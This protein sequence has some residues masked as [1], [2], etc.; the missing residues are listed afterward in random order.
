MAADTPRYAAES[1]Y[2]ATGIAGLDAVLGGGVARRRLY[3]IEGPPGAGKTT[4][5]LHFL[6]AGRD[7]HERCL[8]LTTAETPDEL[9]DAAQAHGWTLE[10]IEVFALPMVTRMAQPDQRQTLF[11]SSEVELD[12][13]MQEVMTILERV[14]PVRVVLDSLSILRDMADDLLA[15]RRQVLTLKQALNVGGC[16]ALVTDEGPMGSDMHVRTLAHGVVRLRQEVTLFG[17][18]QRQVEIVKMRGR[19]F[20]SGRHDLVITTGGIR[21]FPRLVLAAHDTDNTGELHSTGVVRLDALLGGGLNRGTATLLVGAAGTGKSSVTMQC[22]AAALQRGH[23]VAVYLFDERPATWFQRADALGFPLRQ[24]VTHGTL[25]VEQIDPAEM[26]PG[27]F[28]YE[29]QHAVTHQAVHLV[30]I[31]SLTGYVHAM[32]EAH[33]LTLHM[34]QLLT[35]LGQHGATTLLVLDQHGLLDAPIVAPLDL[36]YLADTVLLFRYFE[37]RGTVRRALSVIKRRSG[38]HESTIRE[39]TLGRTALTW[40]SHSPSF[41]GCS[42]GLP[43]MK[44]TGHVVNPEVS[45]F[46]R[47]K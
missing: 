19:P 4:L 16:T 6:L 36:S 43:P 35:W 25:V 39:M 7:N 24:A 9:Q 38:P 15:Y 5:A 10:G 32:P 22:A 14:Q 33:F 40:V 46:R 18:E 12:E 8:W 47:E 27:Q 13:T 42:R 30:I 3:V 17:N 41:V 31:D 21:V 29:V 20:Q 45:P 11:R 44:E 37:D 28:A 26:S 34:H 23:A 1:T 2:A